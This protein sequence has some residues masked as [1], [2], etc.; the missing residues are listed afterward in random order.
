[1]RF[2]NIRDF[3]PEVS[4][5]IDHSYSKEALEE[6][7]NLVVN[8]QAINRRLVEWIT[9]D[10][11]ESKDL[12]DG[13]WAEKRKDWGYTIWVS[14][15]DVAEVVHP[16]TELDLEWLDRATSIYL[17]T[18]AIHMFPEKISTDICSLNWDKKT[19]TMTTQIDLDSQ[20]NVLNTQIYES[21]FYNKKR[22]DYEEFGRQYIETDSEFHEQ[23]FLQS[24][25]A[26]WLYAKRLWKWI[27]NNF[28]DEDIICRWNITPWNTKHIASLTV[29]EFAILTNIVST[30]KD[31][32]EKV[33]AISRNHMPEFRW[34]PLPKSLE[35]AYYSEKM[36]Y[37]LGLQEV[38]YWHNTSP[39]RRYVDL[40]NQR[41]RKNHIRN[42]ELLYTKNEIILLCEYINMQ[43]TAIRLL[44]KEHDF[45]AI[46]T[47]KIRTV[48]KENWSNTPL[49]YKS[50]IPKINHS[51]EN[52]FKVPH[53]ILKEILKISEKEGRMPDWVI[54]TFLTSNETE[55]KKKLKEKVLEDAKVRRYFGIIWVIPWINITEKKVITKWKWRIVI[56]ISYNWK[57]ISLEKSDWKEL[58]NEK[59]LDWPIYQIR[60][61][62]LGNIFDY[63][64]EEKQI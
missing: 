19:L 12:D 40:V 2:W 34:N 60:K 56:S 59:D 47:K 17:S 41:Q 54:R 4:T 49:E 58:K 16:F 50:I 6:A 45:T 43:I 62:T 25:I 57:N 21:T 23:L 36:K 8:D 29:Q 14:I 48:K 18:H 10:W 22:F 35:R 11:K 15:A 51:L 44:Q 24:L 55:F 27:I 3:I 53:I 13:M 20:F 64:I 30:I 46:T 31:I 33:N 37:H 9:I 63:F 5:Q 7:N 52:W 38:Y 1:M 39:I 28:E 32:R 42:E 26:K 61:K